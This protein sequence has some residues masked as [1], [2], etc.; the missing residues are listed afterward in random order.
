V[1]NWIAI[2]S[3]M[4]L[5]YVLQ[6]SLLSALFVVLSRML[7]LPF[8][9]AHTVNLALITLVYLSLHRDVSGTLI[10]AVVFGF[11]GSWFG[12]AWNGALTSSFFLVAFVCGSLRKNLL[13][14][15]DL[16]IALFVGAMSLVGGLL[17]LGAGELFNQ[18]P[19]PF[20][21][22]Y[23]A[24]SVDILVNALAAPLWFRFLKGVDAVTGGIQQRRRGLL[25]SEL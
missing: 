18:V 11:V 23:G 21:H 24:I 12:T 14:K 3:V 25:L 16:S 7:G 5:G 20:E 1:K 22:Q 9:T 17:H 10:W 13:L 6:T 8:L 2:G 15:D 19:H 4:F